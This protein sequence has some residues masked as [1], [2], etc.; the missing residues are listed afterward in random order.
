[1]LL[2][3]DGAKLLPCLCLVLFM[4]RHSVVTNRLST[5]AAMGHLVILG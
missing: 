3:T 4:L 2:K 1:M 5:K